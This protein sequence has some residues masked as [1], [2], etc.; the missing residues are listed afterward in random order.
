[1]TTGTDIPSNGED[2]LRAEFE[3]WLA[4]PEQDGMIYKDED[5][6]DL[7]TRSFA[8]M[9][10]TSGY[11]AARASTPVSDAQADVRDASPERELPP[12]PYCQCENVVMCWHPE[13]NYSSFCY[14][15]QLMGPRSKDR[16]EAVAKYKDLPSPRNEAREKAAEAVIQAA[17]DVRVTQWPM[18]DSLDPRLRDLVQAVDAYM[19]AIED[20]KQP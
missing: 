19:N 7:E 13:K 20:G 6:E 17:K 2:E 4:M 8:E 5:G 1:M 15:C 3:K 12:C 14:G 9:C 16:A 18:A 11:K 10:F